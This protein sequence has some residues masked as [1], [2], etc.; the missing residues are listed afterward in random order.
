MRQVDELGLAENTLIV[1]T[2]DNGGDDGV[3]TNTAFFNAN[4]GLRGAKQTLYEGGIRVPAIFRWK[5]TIA[6]GKT[7]GLSWYFP[8]VM[9]T[10][11]ELVGKPQ[12]VPKRC[13]GISIVPTLLGQAA[14]QAS[15]EFLYWEKREDRDAS[16]LQALR[17]RD[18]KLIRATGGERTTIELYDLKHDPLEKDNLAATNQGRVD[19]MT[20]L[21]AAAHVDAPPQVEPSRPPGLDYR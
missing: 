11:L 18:W 6:A 17:Q 10:L 8:D 12:A 5:G 14:R 2:S 13:D 16:L 4:G 15:H 19:A 1:F 7:N 9:P 21:I 20:K 3:L